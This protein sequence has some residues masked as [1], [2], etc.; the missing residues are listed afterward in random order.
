VVSF[1]EGDPDRPIVLGRVYN[2]DSMPEIPPR[3]TTDP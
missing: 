1:E 2:P 3:I